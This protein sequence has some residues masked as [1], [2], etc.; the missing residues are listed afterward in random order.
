[1]FFLP[2]LTG[3]MHKIAHYASEPYFGVGFHTK[4]L[5]ERPHSVQN[6]TI[7][8]ANMRVSGHRGRFL[9]KRSPAV[10]DE[11]IFEVSGGSARKATLIF[12]EA[13]IQAGKAYLSGVPAEVEV[14]I[15]DN[16]AGKREK[17]SA[18][19]DC[20]DTPIK[21]RKENA[22]QI[23]R[24]TVPG[25]LC[26]QTKGLC[27]MHSCLRITSPM[28]PCLLPLLKSLVRFLNKPATAQKTVYAI[29][30]RR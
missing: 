18:G 22:D 1:M 16:W 3:V 20:Y 26:V 12:K 21:T 10:Y 19:I 9:R 5:L 25:W 11:I 30:D 4:K 28:W 29:F 13:M 7:S 27:G 17:H 2:T 8:Q 15:A 14:T 24:R 23:F 6:R